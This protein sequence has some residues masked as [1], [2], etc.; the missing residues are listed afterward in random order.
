M[1]LSIDIFV[2]GATEHYEENVN[3]VHVINVHYYFANVVW[4]IIIFD[5]NSRQTYYQIPCKLYTPPPTP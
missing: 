4:I 5:D 1:A 3:N 2:T